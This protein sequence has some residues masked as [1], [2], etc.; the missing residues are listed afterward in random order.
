MER[1]TNFR[2]IV[3]GSGPAGCT[4][5]I[6]LSRANLAPLVLEGKLFVGSSDGFLYALDASSGKQIWKYETGEKILGAPNWIKAPLTAAPSPTGGERE[7]HSAVAGDVT[8]Q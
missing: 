7:N 6:Y 1:I 8:V 5:A 2:V 3:V 4:A